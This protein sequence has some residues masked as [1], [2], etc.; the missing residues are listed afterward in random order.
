MKK[1]LLVVIF[2]FPV[3]AFADD[4]SGMYPWTLTVFGGGASLCD[5]AGCFGPSGPVV[6][7]SFGRHMTDR[8]AFELE[9]AVAWT[10]EIQPARVDGATGQ[11]FVPELDRTRFW[12]GANFLATLANF[13]ETSDFFISMGIVGA[14][15]GQTEIVPQGVFGTPSKS[16]GIV[17]G[18]AGGAGMNLWFGDSWGVR[19][20]IR[21]YLT[22]KDLSGIRYTAGLMHKF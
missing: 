2:L 9:G 10:T 11:I 7:G 21:Y 17:G 15:E 19:P 18:V 13:G 6:G 5:E 8:W 12:G 16:I 3:F 1:L 14:Y 4:E 20:E 22:A